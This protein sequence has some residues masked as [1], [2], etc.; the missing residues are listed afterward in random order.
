M[1]YNEKVKFASGEAGKKRKMLSIII[2][3]SPGGDIPHM[4][5]R[6]RFAALHFDFIG[7]I[8]HTNGMNIQLIRNLILGGMRKIYIKPMHHK[9]SSNLTLS[10]LFTYLKDYLANLNEE[11]RPHIL[12]IQ[13]DN[14]AGDNKNRFLQTFLAMLVA[15][16]WFKQVNYY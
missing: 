15:Q 14:A 1:I 6:P 8:N 10:I 2:D 12:M 4:M 16:N 3:G 7:M 5:Q 13:M 9:K 11:E